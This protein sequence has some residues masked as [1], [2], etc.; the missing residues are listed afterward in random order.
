MRNSLYR[1]S[2]GA[3]A[4]FLMSLPALAQFPDDRPD[5]VRFRL[6]GI[7]ANTRYP[8]GGEQAGRPG[9]PASILPGLA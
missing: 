8:D 3:A 4:V 6:G 1:L 2:L 7:F 5:N 9:V